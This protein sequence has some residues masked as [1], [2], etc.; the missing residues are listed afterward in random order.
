MRLGRVFIKIGYVVDLDNEDMVDH[1]KDRI[2]Q[3]L[4]EGLD[5]PNFDALFG[6]EEDA[7]Y[8]WE[9]IPEF[10]REDIIETND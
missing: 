9:D 8:V 1:A 5:Y 6:I 3:N 7:Q 4:G 10:I 2:T